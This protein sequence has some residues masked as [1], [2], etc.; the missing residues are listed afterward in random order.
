MRLKLDYEELNSIVKCYVKNTLGL[1]PAGD[2]DFT[3][4]STDYDQN[5]YAEIIVGYEQCGEEEETD[6]ETTDPEVP[7]EDTGWWVKKPQ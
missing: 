5:V 3:C 2:T 1:D 4:A 7:A 6:E